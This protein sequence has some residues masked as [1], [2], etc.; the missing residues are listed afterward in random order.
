MSSRCQRQSSPTLRKCWPRCHEKHVDDLR[1]VGPRVAVRADRR[2]ELL[3]AGDGERR[4]RGLERRA[5]AQPGDPERL[6]EQSRRAGDRAPGVPQPQLV[7]ALPD[8]NLQ[9]PDDVRRA[10][11]G[12]P[13]CPLGDAPA[14]VGQRGHRPHPVGRRHAAQEAAQAG[15]EPVVE[16]QAE[17]FPATGARGRSAD[18]CSPSRPGSAGGS[19]GAARAQRGRSGQPGSCCPRRPGGRSR[20]RP[21]PPSSRNRRW[22]ARRRRPAP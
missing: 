19:A 13:D 5:G 16:P 21:G 7:E 15:G 1:H 4:Q 22:P 6:V 14:A 11:A 3:Q 9:R 20:P 10:R 2:A 8:G 17:L 18:S 12:V